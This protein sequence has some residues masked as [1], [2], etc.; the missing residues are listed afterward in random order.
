MD[1]DNAVHPDNGIFFS[2]RKTE[3]LAHAATEMNLE[4]I[5]FSDISQTRD[6]YCVIPLTDP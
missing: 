2:L 3:I 5:M 1:K 6:R 4:D